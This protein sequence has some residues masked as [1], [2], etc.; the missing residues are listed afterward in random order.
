M[1][2]RNWEFFMCVYIYVLLVFREEGER[3]KQLSV[4]F[5]MPGQNVK[6][7]PWLGIKPAIVHGTTPN[8]LS[9]IGQGRRWWF[10]CWL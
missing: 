8:Q 3:E 5:S 6:L 1:S 4:A 9:H 10:F 7:V 2:S